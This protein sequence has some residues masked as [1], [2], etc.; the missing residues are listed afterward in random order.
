MRVRLFPRR[1]ALDTHTRA[2][3]PRAADDPGAVGAVIQPPFLE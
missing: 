1:D 2:P 3:A